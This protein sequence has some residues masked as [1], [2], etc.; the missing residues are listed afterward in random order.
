M[1]WRT[2]K[3]QAFSEAFIGEEMIKD[4]TKFLHNAGFLL[5]F[6][7]SSLSEIVIFDENWLAE[8]CLLLDERPLT[9]AGFRPTCE[10]IRCLRECHYN[11]RQ[12]QDHVEA[13]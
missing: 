2:Y 6:D 8:V 4:A 9:F 1:S 13:G 5:W 11:W 3:A 7:Q 12:A 10:P